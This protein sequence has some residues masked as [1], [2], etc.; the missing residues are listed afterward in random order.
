MSRI[1]YIK[2]AFDVRIDSDYEAFY[3][4]SKA[5]VAA[6]VENTKTFLDAVEKYVAERIQK[7]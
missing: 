4:I 7:P 1:A 5:D 6:Q 2:N 3:L